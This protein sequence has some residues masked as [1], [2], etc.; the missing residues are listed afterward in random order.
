MK[1]T[2]EA[3]IYAIGDLHLPGGLDKSMHIFGDHWEGHF[4][5]IAADWRLRVSER[6]IVLIPGDISWAMRLEDALADLEAIGM[7]PGRKIIIRGNHDYWWGAVSALR[8][9]IPQDMSALQNDAIMIEGVVF[10]GSRG[11]VAPASADDSENRKIYARE[12]LRMELSLQQGRKLDSNAPLVV[13]IHYPP[14]NEAGRETTFTMLF[15]QYGASDVVY[16]HLHGA[17]VEYGFQGQIKDVRYHLCSCD[18]L[19]FQLLRLPVPRLCG[20]GTQQRQMQS[21]KHTI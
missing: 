14:C 21:H 18:S 4:D 3:A 13:L 15:E 17:A 10:C 8:R 9:H 20:C 19:N 11:W 6:D 5:R 12:L 1:I 7:L 2:E 16:G